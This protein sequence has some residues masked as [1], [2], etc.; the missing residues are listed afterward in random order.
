M[1][2]RIEKFTFVVEVTTE[3]DDVRDLEIGERVP[4]PLDEARVKAQVEQA[5]NEEVKA[6][7]LL[8]CYV[9]NFYR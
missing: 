3:V 4:S 2:K 9:T 1:Q 6:G 5:I 7:Y 8:E